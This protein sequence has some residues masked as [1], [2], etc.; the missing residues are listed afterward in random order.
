MKNRPGFLLIGLGLLGAIGCM[1]DDEGVWENAGTGVAASEY[2]GGGV[3]GMAGNFGGIAGIG[4]TGGS[5]ETET[6]GFEAGAAGS[7]AEIASPVAEAGTPEAGTGGEVLPGPGGVEAGTGGG[8]AGTGGDTDMP[9]CMQRPSQVVFFGDSYMTMYP[10]TTVSPMVA[11]LAQA[12]GALGPGQ[13][14]RDY[15]FPGT[16]MGTGEIPGQATRALQEDPDI[17]LVAMSGG[18]NDVLIG[19]RQCLEP[20]SSSDPGCQ[21]VIQNAISKAEGM[22][23][24]L[25]A[26]GVPDIIYFFYPHIPPTALLT[27]TAPNEILDYAYPLVREHCEGAEQRYGGA[28]QCHFI[29]LRLLFGDTYQYVN[30]IEGIHPTPAG[31]QMI[32]NEIYGIMKASCL[33]QPASK[34]CCAP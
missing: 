29:D 3:A 24:A 19:A 23:D 21:G 7:V 6:G 13:A 25:V 4:G 5:F 10:D 30:P 18:G 8:E 32:A 16:S 12:D 33:G 2:S 15:S 9:R 11:A 1:T 20:G 22:F 28:I 27:G 26:A 34:G 17:I 31:A 14:Y